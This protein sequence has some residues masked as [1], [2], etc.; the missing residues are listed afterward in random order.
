MGEALKGL[1]GKVSEGLASAAGGA[2]KAVGRGAEALGKSSP[3]TQAAVVGGGT[4]LGYRKAKKKL[5]AIRKARE[6]AKAAKASGG[7]RTL[8]RKILT[9]G[10]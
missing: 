4:Y 2:V 9:R 6:A 7:L 8:V 3:E 10:K 1:P 5:E